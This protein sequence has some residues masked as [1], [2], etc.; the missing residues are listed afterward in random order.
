[1]ADYLPSNGNPLYDVCPNDQRFVMLRIGD[2]ETA[3]SELI[4]VLNSF[5]EL[6]QRIEN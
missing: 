2:E 5:E 1:M 3:A 6:R 4:L